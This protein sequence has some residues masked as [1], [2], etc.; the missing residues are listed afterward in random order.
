MAQQEG[1]R[2]GKVKAERVSQR[3]TSEAYK[4]RSKES[5]E[6]RQNRSTRRLPQTK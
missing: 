1:G 4:R 3:A 5:E 2:I 6:R